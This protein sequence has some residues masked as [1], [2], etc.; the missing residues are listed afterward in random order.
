MVSCILPNTAWSPVATSRVAFLLLQY[1]AAMPGA[2]M[3]GGSPMTAG[4]E[5]KAPQ[6]AKIFPRLD[7]ERS[8]APYILI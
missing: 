8:F 7:L 4:P 1:I 3:S 2:R 6:T 5:T